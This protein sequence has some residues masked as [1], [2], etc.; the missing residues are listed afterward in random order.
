[1]AARKAP[2]V[3]ALKEI[4]AEVAKQYREAEAARM[5][6][7]AADDILGRLKKGEGLEA[8]AKEK[9]LK[10]METGLFQPGG[11]I[12]KLGATPELTEAL[13]QISEKKPYPGQTYLVG[14]NYVVVRFKERGRVDEAEFAA[15]RNM[16]ASSLMQT[17]RMEA[18]KS[19][20]EGSKAALIKEG[21]LEL[22]RDL[23]D[24]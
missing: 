17:K 22:K 21:R 11:A 5:A 12:P 18:V 14:G 13:F 9:G 4:E 3:P 1:V 19:W 2:Y 10:V 20:I 24:L 23:K 6:K 8:V 16:I 7:K 15:E